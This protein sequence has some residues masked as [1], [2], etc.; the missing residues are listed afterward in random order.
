MR[1]I[2]RPRNV[3]VGEG[4]LVR[5]RGQSRKF[6]P[7][8]AAAV[9]VDPV[10]GQGHSLALDGVFFGLADLVAGGA[11]LLAPLLFGG[12][13]MHVAVLGADAGE[14]ALG[15]AHPFEVDTGALGV[16]EKVGA[17]GPLCQAQVRQTGIKFLN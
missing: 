13:Q 17:G 14:D 7:L 10:M 2:R 3:G 9:A 15:A 5:P 11:Q 16:R 1:R 4:D 12:G 8:G 6:H